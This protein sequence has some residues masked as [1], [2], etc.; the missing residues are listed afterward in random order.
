MKRISKNSILFWSSLLFCF[1]IIGC[2]SN[3]REVQKMGFAEFTPSGDADGIN[4]KYTDSG[5]ITANLVSPKMLD[6]ATVQ[7]P[8]TEFPKGIHLTLYDK[9][10]KE[11]YIDSKYAV[12]HKATNIIDLRNDVKIS[13]QEGQLLETQQLYYDQKNEWFFTEKKYKFTSPKG[14]SYG[15]GI[16]FSKDFKKVNSQKISGEVQSTE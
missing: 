15:E 13:N 1:T 3:F 14:V 12:T 16:D 4:L 11:T 10:G 9:S 5:R 8:F 6:Y 2:E 7:Y